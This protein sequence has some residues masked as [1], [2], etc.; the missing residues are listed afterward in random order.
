LVVAVLR[1]SED[2]DRVRFA[3]HAGLAERPKRDAIV[4]EPRGGV[5]GQDRVDVKLFRERLHARRGVDRVANRVVLR[6]LGESDR[7]DDHVTGV[8]PYAELD[9]D[10]AAAGS[11]GV[12]LRD[13]GAHRES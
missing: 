13:A 11:R 9:D 5:T 4:A 1:Q 7:T 8:K 6:A 3:F 2:L 12:E 10:L